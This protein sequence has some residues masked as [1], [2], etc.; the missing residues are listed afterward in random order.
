MLTKTHLVMS[1]LAASAAVSPTVS[2]TLQTE[3]VAAFSNVSWGDINGD[4]LSD[5][6]VIREDGGLRLLRNAGDGT[7][8]EVTG[9]VGL[10]EVKGIRVALLEDLDGDGLAE[11]FVGGAGES[12]L[13]AGSGRSFVDVTHGSGLI[14]LK[15]VLG[16]RTLDYDEDGKPDLYVVAESGSALLHGLGARTFERVDVDLAG[17][18]NLASAGGQTLVIPNTPGAVYAGTAMQEIH[19]PSALEDQADPQSCIGAS[20]V[21]TT[22]SLYPLGTPLNVNPGT[23][24]VQ[25]GIGLDV[26]GSVTANDVQVNGPLNAASI[27]TGSELTAFG[28]NI[29][30]DLKIFGNTVVNSTGQWVGDPTGLVGPQGP[31]GPDGPQGPQGIQG[32]VGSD[33]PQGPQGIQGPIGLQGPVG[34]Q[35]ASPFGLN[36]SSAYYTAGRV[37]IGTTTPSETLDIV[38]TGT[39]VGLSVTGDSPTGTGLRLHNTDS[40]GTDWAM[41]SANDA[42]MVFYNGTGG[43]RY[44]FGAQGTFGVLGNQGLGTFTPGSKLNV[45]GG[46][47]AELTGGSNG[48]IMNG[49]ANGFN[50]VMDNNEIMARNNETASFLHLNYN[51][52]DVTV[53]AEAGSGGRLGIGKVPTEMLDVA[54]TAK[55]HVVQIT[56]G[57]DIVEGFDSS[58]ELEPGTVVIIDAKNEGELIASNG[59]YDRKVAGV[60]S[61]ANGI[62]P[63]LELGQEGVLDGDV[64]VAMSG[65]VYVKASN[66]NG[67]IVPGDR[68]TTASLAGHAM[69]ATDEDRASGAVIGKAMSALDADTG[70]VLV[71]VNLQ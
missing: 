34:P 57:A 39:T 56:G 6:V 46:D 61:G 3:E 54:G 36:G 33:G 41:I 64:P 17:R 71:L 70:L 29:A 67:A 42:R 20:S 32:L 65:R 37:G 50:L 7:L 18:M 44:S 48:Y 31:V 66:E 9:L 52:G 43:T 15:G 5:A 14:G 28:A 12:R 21:P 30:G 62:R 40:A 35:G 58:E 24:R 38:M 10:S 8:T 45:V 68:L 19:C 23:D 16:A 51:G 13:F 49:P 25:I 1:L 69:K 26:T 60:V 47:D 59:A 22:G 4:D 63:G 11:L 55:V 2:P 27:I 53:S